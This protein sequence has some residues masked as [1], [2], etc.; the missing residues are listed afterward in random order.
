MTILADKQ[1][2]VRALTLFE[3]K[4]QRNFFYTLHQYIS[5]D[6]NSNDLF[7]LQ[8]VEISKNTCHKTFIKKHKLDTDT[9]INYLVYTTSNSNHNYNHSYTDIIELVPNSSRKILANPVGTYFIFTTDKNSMKPSKFENKLDTFRNEITYNRIQTRRKDMTNVESWSVQYTLFNKYDIMI[10]QDYLDKS[11]YNVQ[12]YR[13]RLLRKY[14]LNNNKEYERIC[15][16]EKLSG[17]LAKSFT[18]LDISDRTFYTGI[19][20][21]IRAISIIVENITGDIS[22]KVELAT[23]RT[24][25]NPRGDSIQTQYYK[26]L[27]TRR[28]KRAISSIRSKVKFALTIKY[29]KKVMTSKTVEVLNKILEV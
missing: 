25:L 13:Y 17:E 26:A 4:A 10:N 24:N 12:P 20:H 28:I 7:S 21:L 23:R 9:Q 18:L 5:P 15:K 2:N 3:Q 8:V 11:G 27:V 16:I 1:R 29:N 22:Y 14:F 6:F 19:P